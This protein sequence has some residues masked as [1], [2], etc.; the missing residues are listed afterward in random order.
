MQDVFGIVETIAAEVQIPAS[1]AAQMLSSHLAQL[2]PAVFVIARNIIVQYSPAYKVTASCKE[3]L[4]IRKHFQ[5]NVRNYICGSTLTRDSG[6]QEVLCV[7][8]AG[9]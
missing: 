7:A 6:R 8:A 2:L 1:S 4:H 3:D 9:R 5:Q